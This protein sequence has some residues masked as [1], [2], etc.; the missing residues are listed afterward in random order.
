MNL[1]QTESLPLNSTFAEN[2]ALHTVLA[3]ACK[4]LDNPE[5]DHLSIM[6]AENTI[7]MI[8]NSIELPE[9]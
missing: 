2:L 9:Q 4:V 8:L 1:Q 6:M 7:N 3:E 5:S